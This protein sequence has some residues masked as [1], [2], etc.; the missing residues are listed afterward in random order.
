MIEDF[1]YTIDT[2]PK[3]NFCQLPSYFHIC[4]CLRW[5]LLFLKVKLYEL[6]RLHKMF[7]HKKLPKLMFSLFFILRPLSWKYIGVVVN[8]PYVSWGKFWVVT[9]HTTNMEALFSWFYSSAT[10]TNMFTLQCEHIC[11]SFRL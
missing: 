8:L 7:H 2:L 4:A 9:L 6:W 3:R 11:E 1:F 5:N 10:V